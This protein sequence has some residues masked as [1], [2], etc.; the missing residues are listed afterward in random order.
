VPFRALSFIMNN[1][2]SKDEF[3]DMVLIM[4]ES[5]YIVNDAKMLYL[6]RFPERQQPSHHTFRQTLARFRESGSV[7]HKKRQK[8]GHIVNEETEI[9]VL[10]SVHVNPQVSTRQLANELDI[11]QSSVSKIL[12]KHK[13]H[14]Y[15]ISLNQELHG[16]DFNNRILFCNWLLQKLR[17]NGDFLK[18]VMFTDEATFKNNAC[19]NRHNL[20]YYSVNNPNWSRSIDNQRIW[21]IN[22][23][24]GIVG[25]NVIGPY[26]FE[27]TLDG[28]AYLNFLRNTLNG[29]MEDVPLNIRQFMWYQHD[30]AAPHYARNVREFMNNQWDQQWLGRGG[31]VAWPARSPDLTPIDFFCGDTSKRKFTSHRQQIVKI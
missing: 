20:H 21:S 16:D 24:G 4:A 14:P 31:P 11:S 13:F 1:R 9:Q 3:I 18:F 23:W 7:N 28:T 22:V 2:Y 26:F 17:D 30:G 5:K 25:D 12:R 15:H 27:G 8:N 29:L 19:V 6:E 10:A